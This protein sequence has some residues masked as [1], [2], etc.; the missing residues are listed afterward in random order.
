MTNENDLF[1]IMDAPL[2]QELF[3]KT[4]CN[5]FL[6]ES[7]TYLL[8]VDQDGEWYAYKAV[9]DC[10]SET[11]FESISN[12]ENIID[13]PIITEDFSFFYCVDSRSIT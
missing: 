8:L 6:D 12:P 10:C 11:W 5:I 2:M 1:K 9:G 13:S 4:I 7:A 3:G